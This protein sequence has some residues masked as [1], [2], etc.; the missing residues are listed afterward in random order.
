MTFVMFDSVCW[1]ERNPHPTHSLSGG[2][3]GSPHCTLPL[4]GETC[5][6]AFPPP[7]CFILMT[8]L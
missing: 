6:G 4:C 1:R 5:L 3:Q 7:V 2:G 8:G